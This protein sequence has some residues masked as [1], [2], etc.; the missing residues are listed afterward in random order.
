MRSFYKKR[1]LRKKKKISSSR[2]FRNWLIV[3][4]NCPC[5]TQNLCRVHCRRCHKVGSLQHGHPVDLPN[6][7]WQEDFEQQFATV[8]AHCFVQC[9]VD[10]RWKTLEK[11]LELKPIM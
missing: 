4:N 8:L 6:T 10:D 7:G 3:P 5:F 2:I 11:I 1:S 9:Q